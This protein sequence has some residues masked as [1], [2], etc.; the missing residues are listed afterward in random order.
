[1]PDIEVREPTSTPQT[2]PSATAPPWGPAAD[3]LDLPYWEGLRVGELRLQRCTRCQRWIW[4][5][6]WI[7]PDCHT[8]DPGWEAVEPIGTV[9]AWSRTFQP[10]ITELADLVPYVT[11]LVALPHA[12]DRRVLG[13]AAEGVE[14]LRVGDRVTGS[15][16]GDPAKRWP[17]LEWRPTAE[18]GE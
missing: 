18:S 12:G 17:T 3:G 14:S 4:G 8:F 5:P 15:I 11:V 13:F 16:V 2:D 9:Y 7:C 6:Q 10:F 1:M